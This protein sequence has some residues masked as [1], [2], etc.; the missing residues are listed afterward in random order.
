MFAIATCSKN[1]YEREDQVE[2][3]TV[4]ALG[5]LRGIDDAIWLAAILGSQSPPPK[6]SNSDVIVPFAMK[7]TPMYYGWFT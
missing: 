6:F 1:L 5:E 3:V 7:T 2:A 4:S